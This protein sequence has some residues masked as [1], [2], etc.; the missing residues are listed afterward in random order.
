MG[1]QDKPFF[2]TQLDKLQMQTHYVLKLWP[3]FYKSLLVS[4]FIINFDSSVEHKP[5]SLST[6]P[7]NW[8]TQ[9]QVFPLIVTS[10]GN[11]CIVTSSSNTCMYPYSTFQ[12]VKIYYFMNKTFQL[13][14]Y[15]YS[16]KAKD[17][18]YIL[19]YNV[20]LNQKCLYVS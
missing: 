18:I 20:I 3:W 19:L 6:L 15:F 11:T 7:Q 8:V 10:S 17:I 16:I 12:H 13:H 9:I 14:T 2:C 4:V 5:P 1:S